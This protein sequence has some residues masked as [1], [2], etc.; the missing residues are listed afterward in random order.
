MDLHGIPPPYSMQDLFRAT[1][2][3]HPLAYR[4]LPLYEDIVRDVRQL[5]EAMGVA[6]SPMAQN[7]DI[8]S[9]RFG[10]PASVAP[11]ARIRKAYT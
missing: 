4:H 3:E 7:N 11:L 8:G 5:G 9:M 10:Q 1:P 6:E 2:E